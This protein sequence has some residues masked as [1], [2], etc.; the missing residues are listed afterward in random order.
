MRLTFRGYEK[1]KEFEG[2]RLTAYRDAVG[3][4]T[5]GYGHTIGVKRGMTITQDQADAYF[6]AYLDAQEE[7]LRKIVTNHEKL[8]DYQWDAIVSF[9]YNVGLGNFKKSTMLAKILKNPEDPTIFNEFGRWTKAGDKKLPGLVK[10]RAWE[11]ARWTGN[12]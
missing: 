9:S 11:A 8:T 12:D 3:V 5:I 1:I 10:R 2:C 6:D 4:W 7:V